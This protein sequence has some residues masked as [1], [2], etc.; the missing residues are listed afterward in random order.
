MDGNYGQALLG[1]STS[2][3]DTL[4]M[5]WFSGQANEATLSLSFSC[6]SVGL[7]RPRDLPEARTEAGCDPRG[8]TSELSSLHLAMLLLAFFLPSFPSLLLTL[9]FPLLLGP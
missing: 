1:A 6:G 8:L 9:F 7:K 5:I 4:Y 3:P 2:R